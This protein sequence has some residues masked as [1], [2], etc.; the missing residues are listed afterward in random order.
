M[1][2]NEDELNK[3]IDEVT[4][5]AYSLPGVEVIFKLVKQ[6]QSWGD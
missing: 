3:F 4:D 1:S 5:G 6:V 2:K